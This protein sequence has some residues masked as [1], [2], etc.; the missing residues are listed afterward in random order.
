MLR[1]LSLLL[2]LGSTPAL[3][4][5]TARSGVEI[6][7]SIV[8]LGAIRPV[9]GAPIVQSFDDGHMRVG[10]AFGFG[11]RMKKAGFLYSVS[12]IIIFGDLQTVALDERYWA[13]WELDEDVSIGLSHGVG[14]NGDG[15]TGSV[16]IW[17]DIG[18]GPTIR[19]M[20]ED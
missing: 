5:V 11:L 19:E 14:N 3:S 16:G 7:T 15:R 10:N 4:E 2:V 13:T 1:V 9:I 8:E 12:R 18:K 20:L 17:W 6:Q